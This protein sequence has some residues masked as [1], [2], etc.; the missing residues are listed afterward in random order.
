M[1]TRWLLVVAAFVLVVPARAGDVKEEMKQLDGA[2]APAKA[3]LAGQSLPDETLKTM[4]LVLAGG[5]YKLEVN[6]TVADQGTLTI[7]PAKKPKAMD[8]KGTEGPNKG[9]TF[10]AIYEL[11]GDSL[12]ICYDLTGKERPTEFK[13]ELKKGLFLA[14][15]QR[16]K[17]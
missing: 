13:A 2:W 9:K 1:K 5:N 15:Y 10:L 6:G 14:T 4:K 8:I 3:E 11:K 12:R 7:D 17:P 16:V